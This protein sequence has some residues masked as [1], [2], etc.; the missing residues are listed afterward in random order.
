MRA[1]LFLFHPFNLLTRLV[2]TCSHNGYLVFELQTLTN[3]QPI[4][5]TNGP[6]MS[7]I[8]IIFSNKR[9]NICDKLR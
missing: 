2:Q 7:Y 5:I 4:Q 9:T 1:H 6:L 3:T 8:V